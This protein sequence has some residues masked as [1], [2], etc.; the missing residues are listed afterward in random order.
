MKTDNIILRLNIDAQTYNRAEAHCLNRI[1]EALGELHEEGYPGGMI[2]W[3]LHVAEIKW[4]HEELQLFSE[5]QK[6]LAK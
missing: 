6:E 1:E 5:V 3:A 4:W 2:A